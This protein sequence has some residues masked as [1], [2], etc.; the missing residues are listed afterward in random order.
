M[1]GLMLHYSHLEALRKD[2]AGASTRGDW[3]QSRYPGRGTHPLTP[4]GTGSGRQ[5]GVAI[6]R[7][8][9]ERSC[10]GRGTP[11]TVRLLPDGT[12]Y[13]D[14]ALQKVRSGERGREYAAARLTQFGARPLG[15]GEEG[16]AWLRRWLP[17]S[18][19]PLRHPGN[20]RYAWSLGQAR[21]RSTAP[22]P[23]RLT[24]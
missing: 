6:V 21:L 17:S 2:L 24:V 14:R 1:T 16:R 9:L 11:R 15:L 8:P 12:T 7:F 4:S 13:S 10:L 5:A 18:T 23:K 22:Y 3:V 19:R 20:H